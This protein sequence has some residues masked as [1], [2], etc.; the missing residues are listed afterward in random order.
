MCFYEEAT[1]SLHDARRKREN[2][3]EFIRNPIYFCLPKENQIGFRIN[4]H[5][6]EQKARFAE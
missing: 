4:A 6:Q 2:D 5:L 1:L 3:G